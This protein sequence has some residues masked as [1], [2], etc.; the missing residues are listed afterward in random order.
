[1]MNIFDEDEEKEKAAWT[2]G[3]YV[4]DENGCENCGRHRVCIC[5]NGK[6]RCEKCNWSPELKDYAPVNN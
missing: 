6:R 2:L 3:D 4:N 1:M 5:P